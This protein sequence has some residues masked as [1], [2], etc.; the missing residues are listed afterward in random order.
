MTVSDGVNAIIFNDPNEEIPGRFDCGAGGGGTL[1]IGPPWLLTTATRPYKGRQHHAI[2]EAEIIVNDGAKC[3]LR[4]NPCDATEL[5]VHELGHT[6]GLGHSCGDAGSGACQSAKKA[7][8]VMHATNINGRCGQLGSFDIKEISKL[9]GGGSGGGASSDLEAPSSL[10]AKAISST[11]VVLEWKDNSADED[12]FV[13]Q[14]KIEG[15]AF[16]T[17]GSVSANSES[18]TVFGLSSSTTYTFRVRSK[19]ASTRSEFSNPATVTT[20]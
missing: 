16:V 4:D 18:A 6:L 15:T 7:E 1:A 14:A 17:L 8:A 2:V 10:S 13:V 3:F 5:Y 11:E 20:P 9:Y 19:R 12:S